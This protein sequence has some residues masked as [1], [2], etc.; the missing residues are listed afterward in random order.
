MQK[1]KNFKKSIMGNSTS[2][3]KHKKKNGHHQH[4]ATTMVGSSSN[5]SSPHYTSSVVNSDK[6][7]SG[8]AGLSID[9]IDDEELTALKQV[10]LSYIDMIEFVIDSIPEKKDNE[11]EPDFEPIFLQLKTFVTSAKKQLGKATQHSQTMNHNEE[12]LLTV[13]S[14]DLPDLP[15]EEPPTPSV[16]TLH[17]NASGHSTE[18]LAPPS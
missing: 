1:L 13:R 7:K 6:E 2:A 12:R 17:I 11:P 9:Q 4:A 10:C 14:E 5:K 15:I 3:H 16:A 18:D 8:I